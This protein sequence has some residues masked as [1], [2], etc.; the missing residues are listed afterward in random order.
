MQES[1]VEIFMLDSQVLGIEEGVELK[2]VEERRYIFNIDL[3]EFLCSIWFF[4]FVIRN[5]EELQEKYRDKIKVLEE[6][7]KIL[8][9]EKR[10]YK[11]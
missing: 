10:Q 6:R 4:F 3:D 1:L 11:W 7:K 9:E 5:Y 2:N 8:K